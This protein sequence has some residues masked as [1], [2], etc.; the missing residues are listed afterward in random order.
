MSAEPEDPPRLGVDDINAIGLIEKY[1]VGR[2]LS[3]DQDG[4]IT[5]LQP[6]KHR[7]FVLIPETD[8]LARSALRHYAVLART[9]GRIMLGDDIDDWIDEVEIRANRA[10]IAKDLEKRDHDV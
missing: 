4:D 3:R 10:Q 2:I 9:S 5:E 1:Y 7:V 6:V 8:P